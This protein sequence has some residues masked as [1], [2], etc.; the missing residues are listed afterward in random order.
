[1]V[2]LSKAPCARRVHADETAVAVLDM[3]ANPTGPP[4]ASQPSG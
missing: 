3:R 4:P 2:G 1:V